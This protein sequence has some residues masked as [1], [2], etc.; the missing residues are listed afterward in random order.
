MKT[1]V[2]YARFSCSK[3]REASIDDQIRVCSEWCEDNGYTVARIYSDHALSG[4]TDERPEFQSMI[5]NAGESDI[6][7]VYMWDRFSRDKYDSTIY[8]K[9][10]AD[11]GVKVISATEPMPDGIEAILLESIY[12]AMAAM[13]SA[14]TAKRVKRG[15]EGNAMKCHYNGVRIFGYDVDENGRY[16]LNE[17]EAEIVREIFARK[18]KHEPVNHI[19]E[20]LAARGIGAKGKPATYGFVY[21]LLKNERYTGVYQWGG[22]RVE[23]GM[24]QIIDVDTFEAAQAAKP[25]KSP[26][27]E[28]W[29]D[30]TLS[31]RLICGE[32]GK[33]M[34]G[35]SGRGRGNK[36]YHYYRCK[37]CGGV[38]PVRADVLEDGIAAALR[39]M[40][41][42][43]TTALMVADI[44]KELSR[45]KAA[46]ARIK[47]IE[48]QIR[49]A[50]SEIDNLTK[51]VAKGF[52][53]ARAQRLIDANEKKVEHLT[54][55]IEGQRAVAGIDVEDFAD[56][57]QFGATLTD[58]ALLNA[59]VWQV[60]LTDSEVLVTLT[61]DIKDNEPARLKLPPVRLVSDWWTLC[62][63]SRTSIAVVDGIIFLRI[64]RA[65]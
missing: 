15:M 16:V 60:L 61:Y 17:S 11:K 57:L 28:T 48:S 58:K 56:F 23:G 51:A 27:T 37:Q 24:P 50:N 54:R 49:E 38:K 19:A 6:V 47:D 30:Y 13:E 14:N 8:K 34:S 35:A 21:N 5:S 63:E 65:A 4:R 18:I 39:D 36:K 43:R 22:V 1:A 41:T 25:K 33:D 26:D 55:R 42:D 59:F 64:L 46:E 45:D 9:K 31:G 29:S 10:L 52:D 7:L 62:K 53:A 32:C 12:E 44:V 2:I 40:F 20:D 3:Q